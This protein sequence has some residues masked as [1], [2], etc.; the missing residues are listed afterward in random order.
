M[1]DKRFSELKERAT[2]ITQLKILS[3]TQIK[4][5]KRERNRISEICVTV[6]KSLIHEHTHVIGIPKTEKGNNMAEK[7]IFQEILSNNFPNFMKN[8]E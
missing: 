6:S 8:T 1:A 3:A 5:N 7:K 2:E 4:H